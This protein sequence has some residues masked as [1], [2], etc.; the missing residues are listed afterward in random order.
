[1]TYEIT[2]DRSRLTVK[3][4]AIE[5]DNLKRLREDEPKL[6]GTYATES[7]VMERLICNSELSW[8]DPADT[9]D[10]TDAPLL[11]IIGSEE[12]RTREQTGPYGAMLCGAGNGVAWYIPNLERWYV[13]IL[14]R[15]GYQPY[16]LRSFM[17]D[18]ADK[19]EAVFSNKW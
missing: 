11:G 4:D 16:A 3:V 1:M 10:L 2:E 9:G 7:E 14:E 5:Q 12:E 17:D 19:G 8:I 6:W 18:L 15:W 13:P